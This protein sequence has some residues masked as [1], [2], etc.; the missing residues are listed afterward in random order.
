MLPEANAPKECNP[1]VRSVSDRTTAVQQQASR[2]EA[3]AYAHAA[4]TKNVMSDISTR[5]QNVGTLAK[6]LFQQEVHYAS[7]NSYSQMSDLPVLWTRTSGDLRTYAVETKRIPFAQFNE[8][9]V[10]ADGR[11]S[12]WTTST[13][14]R[15]FA[16]SITQCIPFIQATIPPMSVLAEDGTY[17]P[18]TFSY[19]SDWT[20]ENFETFAG[21]N[22]PGNII[23]SVW[24]SAYYQESLGYHPE[25]SASTNVRRSVDGFTG[26]SMRYTREWLQAY[27]VGVADYTNTT[28]P[29]SI[30][31]AKYLPPDVNL[32]DIVVG[33]RFVESLVTDTSFWHL[34]NSQ[35]SLF[36]E[37]TFSFEGVRN[38]GY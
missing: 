34:N 19:A 1:W 32:V 12:V 26:Y 33:W 17:L 15:T 8:L 7:V 24:P 31:N 18:N 37:N 2:V 10:T 11:S 9:I 5:V 35:I 28:F 21:Y 16:H 22:I 36:S 23:P 38:M 3:N 4:S 13:L 29:P 27:M 30:P 25:F 6:R 14:N 20:V